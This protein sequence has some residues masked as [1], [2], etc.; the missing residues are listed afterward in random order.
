MFC[1]LALLA[2]GSGFDCCGTTA[3]AGF[4]GGGD[5]SGPD[6]RALLGLVAEVGEPFSNGLNPKPA[7]LADREKH[8]PI[9]RVKRNLIDSI[10]TENPGKSSSNLVL[11]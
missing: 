10:L 5:C 3:G 4:G 1:G 7:A 6:G 8:K 2:D 11:E 9:R